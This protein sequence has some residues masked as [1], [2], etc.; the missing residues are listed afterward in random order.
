MVKRPFNYLISIF[1]VQFILFAQNKSVVAVLD[2][3]N[4]DPGL[5]Q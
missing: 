4:D 3:N 1:L 2:F 5:Q